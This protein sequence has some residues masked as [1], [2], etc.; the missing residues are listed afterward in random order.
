MSI[1][2]RLVI[3]GVLMA[4]IINAVIII[5]SFI[6][7]VVKTKECPDGY[8]PSTTS[9]GDCSQVEQTEPSSKALINVAFD[10]LV[11]SLKGPSNP[12]RTVITSQSEWQ[13]FWK[14]THAHITPFPNIIQV[15]FTKNIVVAVVIGAKPTKGYAVKMSEASDYGDRVIVRIR[16][17]LPPKNCVMPPSPISPYHIIK[18]AKVN[19]PIE[20]ETVD[21]SVGSVCKEAST[22]SF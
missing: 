3:Y 19:K 20:F 21:E 6:P 18:F 7:P 5:I 11:I 9:P 17:G 22:E 2:K 8:L 13:T 15:D 12:E 4:V 1:R 14:R 16:H 10:T